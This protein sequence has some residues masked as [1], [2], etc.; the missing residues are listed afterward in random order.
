M[1]VNETIVKAQLGGVQAKLSFAVVKPFM[2]HAERWFK[3]QVGKELFEVL[4]D[5]AIDED[6]KVLQELAQGAIC[7]FGFAMAQ[8]H[9]HIK[10]GDAGFAKIVPASHV[11]LTKWEYLQMADSNT[12]MID[13]CLEGFWAELDAL[14]VKPA[15][16]EESKAYK[17]RNELF[18]RSAVETTEHLPLVKN[19]VRMYE[20]LKQ[21]IKR[22][23]RTYLLPILTK[24]VFGDLKEKLQDPDEELSEQD[25]E[26]LG[27]IQYALAPVAMYEALPYMSVLV[28]SEGIRMV[29]KTDSTRNEIAAAMGEKNT[30]VQR[31]WNDAQFGFAEIRKFMA[32]HATAQEY[33]SYYN[34]NLKP[35]ADEQKE[36]DPKAHVIL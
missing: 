6:F 3:E 9:I 31:L 12:G 32:E 10:V 18:L 35:P 8:P 2:Q 23:E 19:S 1:I 30:L 27:L 15:G 24:E 36:Q 5:S 4:D 29:V 13:L 17:I 11:A 21:Y 26:L 20:A 14:E 34:Q 7:W 33:T 22:A 16:W 28:D 25:K